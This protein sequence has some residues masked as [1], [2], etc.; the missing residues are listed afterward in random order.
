MA[1]L[2][3]EVRLVGKLGVYVYKSILFYI[4]FPQLYTPLTNGGL[5]SES[6]LYLFLSLNLEFC[7]VLLL[8]ELGL[9]QSF[10]RLSCFK[11]TVA[12]FC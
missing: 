3:I 2:I 6:G 10:T 8:F 5:L 1:C 11:R 4:K 7:E 9:V 12:P